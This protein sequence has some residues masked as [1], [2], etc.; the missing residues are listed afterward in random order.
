MLWFAV[1]LSRNLENGFVF[2]TIFSRVYQILEVCGEQDG[3]TLE[4]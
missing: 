3:G 2:D 4:I 1:E